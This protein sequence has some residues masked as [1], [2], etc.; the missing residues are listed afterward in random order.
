MSGKTL[1]SH[2]LVVSARRSCFVVRFEHRRTR[3]AFS[4]RLDATEPYHVV[5]GYR[6]PETNEFLRRRHRGVAQN[7][8][9]VDGRAVDLFLPDRELLQLR[10]A[11]LDLAAGGVGYYPRSGLVHLDTGPA[12]TW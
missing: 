11:A 1:R 2:S 4:S 3:S 8:F 12:R 10:S 6:S 9:H 5:C 7:S